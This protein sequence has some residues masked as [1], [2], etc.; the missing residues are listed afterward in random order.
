MKDRRG[1]FKRIYDG[2]I[3]QRRLVLLYLLCVILPLF[4]T[5]GVFLYI[6]MQSEQAQIVH[7]AENK[8]R[9]VKEQFKSMVD[10]ASQI[11]VYISNA[12]T[13]TEILD[14]RYDSS[15]SYYAA[16]NDVKSKSMIDVLS[17]IN[18]MHVTIFAD[19]DTIMNGGYCARIDSVK[20]TE[21][22]KAFVDNG[23]KDMLI[24]L[25]DK[26]KFPSVHKTKRRIYY[27]KKL[28]N[29]GQ[30]SCEKIAQVEIEYPWFVE[31]LGGVMEESEE[32]QSPFYLVCNGKS[33]INF[34][35]G[36]NV[37]QDFEDFTMNADV[38]YEESL[39]V[40]GCELKII[41]PESEGVVSNVIKN[42][43][44]PLICLL[45]LNAV[46]PWMFMNMGNAVARGRIKEQESDIARQNAELLALHSQ[47]NPHFLFNA[48]ESIRM[49]S[50]LRG[51][52]ETA[53]MV[54]NL[55]VMERQNA[56]WSHDFVSI[57]DEITFVEAYLGL[58]KYRFGDRLS[59]E[60]DV[61]EDTKDYLIPRL[62]IVTFVENSCVHGI[63]GKATPGWVFVRTYV[64]NDMLVAEIED[65]GGGISEEELKQLEDKMNN[66][67]IDKLKE[68]GRIGIVN[69]CLRLKMASDEEA[70]FEIDSEKGIGTTISVKLPLNKLSKQEIPED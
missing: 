6:I 11:S 56:D 32:S 4:I 38:T 20:N 35:G 17:G 28:K 25:Y 26:D 46:F 70:V 42:H 69:A 57:K 58:Q 29:F 51:E 67:S 41:I 8:A 13:F 65:T 40:Y 22:Y 27:V 5:D 55:A 30:K 52:S 66:A 10:F 19:N 59:Y 61:D 68:K 9:D 1:L 15:Y 64:E 62:S 36:N 50:I 24:F 7:T 53:S 43:K 31:K 60:L 16:Y 63:E 47:I 39:N 54:E 44:F 45:I 48:L 21:W 3:S 34:E 12:H 49:H 37:F 2:A 18:S 14:E 23:S 33:I